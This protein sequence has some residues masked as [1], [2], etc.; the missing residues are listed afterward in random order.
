MKKALFAEKRAGIFSQLKKDKIHR[1]KK[2]LLFLRQDKKKERHNTCF[3]VKLQSAQ[4]TVPSS[5]LT[6]NYG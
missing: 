4:N 5:Y 6:D 1:L 3:I 2:H